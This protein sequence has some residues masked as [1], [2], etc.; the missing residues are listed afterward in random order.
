[1]KRDSEKLDRPDAIMPRRMAGLAVPH[2][3][4]NAIARHEAQRADD[5]AKSRHQARPATEA[6][7]EKTVARTVAAA[8]NA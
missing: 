6:T 7:A 4:Q 3:V 5:L 8:R 2:H 1:M